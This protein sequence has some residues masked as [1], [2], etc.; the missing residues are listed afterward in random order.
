M[1]LT[2]LQ[3]VMKLLAA[4]AAFDQHM[5]AL[6]SKYTKIPLRPGIGRQHTQLF[7]AGQSIQRLLGFQQ[8]QRTGQTAGIKFLQGDFSTCAGI[9]RRRS[10]P[11]QAGARNVA[12]YTRSQPSSAAGGSPSVPAPATVAATQRPSGYRIF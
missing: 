11:A 12:R 3:Q 7:T 4:N 2:F 9:K 1:G 10:M 5:A 8:R 6:F